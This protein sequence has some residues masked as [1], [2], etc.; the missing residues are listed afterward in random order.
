ME[1]VAAAHPGIIVRLTLCIPKPSGDSL[2]GIRKG[3]RTA[4]GSKRV[5]FRHDLRRTAASM[6]TGMGIPG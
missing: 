5:N 1:I 6:M 3:Y 2:W 4:A